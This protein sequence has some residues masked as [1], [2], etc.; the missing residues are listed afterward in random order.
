VPLQDAGVQ[1]ADSRGVARWPKEWLQPVDEV[2]N[3]LILFTRREIQNGV[4]DG[5]KANLGYGDSGEWQLNK[6]FPGAAQKN[7]VALVK[8]QHI[9]GY[10]NL[11]HC[12]PSSQTTDAAIGPSKPQLP[13]NFG[14]SGRVAG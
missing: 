14:L 5:G 6:L 3:E 7:N 4:D 12:R 1:D 11:A 10:V 9:G 2:R 8:A 13:P